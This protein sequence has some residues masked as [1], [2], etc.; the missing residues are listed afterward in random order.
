MKHAA[1]KVRASARRASGRTSG[2][3]APPESPPATWRDPWAWATLLA[4]VPLLVRCA[5]T[6]LGEPVA[7]DFDFLR[8]SL[9]GGVGSLLDGGGS[10]SFWRPLAH[11]LYYATLGPLLV[12]RPEWVAALH[13][14]LLAAGSLL[15]FRVLRA[16]LGGPA[17]W[18]AASFPMFAESTR[19]LVSWPTQFVDVGLYFFVSVAIHETWRRRLPAALIA[20][21]LA[22]LCKELAVVGVLLLPWLPGKWSRTERRAWLAGTA[23]LTAVWAALYLSVRMNAHLSLPHGIEQ[24][25]GVTAVSIAGR[26]AW[27]FGGSA[28]SLMSLPLAAAPQALLALA[29]GILAFAGVGLAALMSKAVRDRL[30]KRREWLAWGGLWFVLSTALLAPIHPLWQPNRAH[31]GSTGAGIVAAAAFTAVEPWWPLAF[32]AG[33]LAL[34]FLAPAAAR[35]VSD[36]PPESGA[37]MD[38]ARL[39][40]LQRF[41][42]V[43]RHELTSEFP[44]PRPG[45]HIMTGNL[46]H[47]LIYALGGDRAI[48]VWYRDTTLATTT[49]ARLDADTTLAVTCYLQY[50]PKGREQL[51]VLGIDGLRAQLRAYRQLRAGAPE[52]A[53]ASLAQADSLAPDPRFEV[54]HGNNAAYRAQACLALGRL[55][56][57]EREA[58]RALE[59][60]DWDPNAW[61]ATARVRSARGDVDGAIA[62]VHQ[63]LERQPGNATALQWL[64]QLEARRKR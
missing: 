18:F 31:Y 24:Q 62:A 11:Q 56:D 30:V 14:L 21:G 60:D 3:A 63:L 58:R 54:F 39:S 25:S 12:S 53:L 47:G 15:V 34:L 64:K 43:S 28:R 10:S 1:E 57:A 55:D 42:A 29:L 2:P 8:R 26:L 17:A 59:L 35:N 23:G 46:P 32:A 22:L 61:S 13:A 6:P 27:A 49:F 7:E 52:A 4:V 5:G 20:S 36:E 16:P 44:H 40:R 9:F 51:V 41:M 37:F 50:Q 33:R 19:T 48:Q 38:F 45:E